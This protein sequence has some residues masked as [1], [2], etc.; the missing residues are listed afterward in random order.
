MFKIGNSENCSS[1]DSSSFVFYKF[2][3]DM[4]QSSPT[5]IIIKNGHGIDVLKISNKQKIPSSLLDSSIIVDIIL[6]FAFNCSSIQLGETIIATKQNWN[7][8]EIVV[9]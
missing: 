7:G 9:N 8:I 2:I 5:K 1:A 4:S 6:G 3:P